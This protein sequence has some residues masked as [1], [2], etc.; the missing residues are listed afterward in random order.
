MIHEPLSNI[1]VQGYTMVGRNRVT[2]DAALVEAL[3]DLAQQTPVFVK[4]VTGYRYDVVNDERLLRLAAHTFIIRRLDAVI[5][6][7]YMMNPS[8]TSTEVG[9]ENQFEIFR[10]V[11]EYTGTCPVVVDADA[12]LDDPPE[13]VRAYCER[14]G[15]PFLPSALSWQPGDRQEWSRTR[16]WH[17]GAAESSGFYQ[18]RRNHEVDVHN[19]PILS[20]YYRHH[21]PYYQLLHAKR[22][23]VPPEA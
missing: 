23:M 2:T 7:H 9:Y 22:L 5:A 12:L 17:R 19:D 21:L 1:I 20:A 15:I 4:E 18:Q 11:H 8:L 6:S 10:L 16:K 14:V 3:F 13:V